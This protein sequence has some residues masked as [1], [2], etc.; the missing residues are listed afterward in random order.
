MKGK[1]LNKLSDSF[2]AAMIMDTGGSLDN[3]S[4]FGCFILKN[5]NLR[6]KKSINTICIKTFEQKNKNKKKLKFI[7]KSGKKRI[8]ISFKQNNQYIKID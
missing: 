7:S 3:I 6:K 8:Y 5:K 1:L 2:L 4:S